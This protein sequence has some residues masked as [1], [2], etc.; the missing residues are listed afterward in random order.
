MKKVVIIVAGGRGK[1]MKSDIPKQFLSI[2]GFPVLMHTAKKFYRHD[3]SIRIIIVLPK[4]QIKLWKKLCRDYKFNY[5]HDIVQGGVT[6]FHSVKNG[7]SKIKGDDWLVAI[8][9]GVRPLVSP[10]TIRRCF[11]KAEASGNAIP[12]IEI[13][14]SMRE[15]SK[16]G[17]RPVDRSKFKLIQTPQVF[18]FKLLKEAFKQDYKPEFTDDA[19]V[20]ESMGH[21]IKLVEGNK[22]N[23]KITTPSD[24]LVA[25][26]YLKKIK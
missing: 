25:E 3:N 18:H 20:V 26:S 13:P 6:R 16:S 22:E 24:L 10:D 1:R 15:I 9:D 14:E 19:S 23:I 4:T 11:K 21:A 7:L 17:N 5:A 12:V 8:H 2:Y